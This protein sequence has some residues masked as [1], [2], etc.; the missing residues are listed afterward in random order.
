M[1]AP[2]PVDDAETLATLE[3]IWALDHGL[4]TV[5]RAMHARL[6]VTGPQRFVVRM[7]G[8]T[9][10]L[11]AGALARSLHD[12]PSTLTAM[13]KRL[14]AQGL[15]VREG[16]PEDQRR[17]RLRLTAEGQAVDRLRDG[18]AE[19]AVHAALASVPEADAA[20]FRRVLGVL[21]AELGVAARAGD[22]DSAAR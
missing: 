16:D 22:E 17:V 11:T 15:V 7:V 13:L 10:G 8:R 18:T 2:R 20:T 1:A 6:G 3:A 9:P 14:V 4:Q 19:S 12:H 21:A 5:S